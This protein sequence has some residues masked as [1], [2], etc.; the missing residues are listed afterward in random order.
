MYFNNE[1]A[2]YFRKH[3]L[4]VRVGLKEVDDPIPICYCFGYTRRMIL[5][6]VA[7]TGYSTAA[8]RIKPEVRAG[9]CACEIKNPSGRCCLGEVAAIVKRRTSLGQKEVLTTIERDSAK[10]QTSTLSSLT[11]S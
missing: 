2:S 8:D 11:R 10:R 3:D 5:N 7:E 1:R 9:N 4:S 6:E